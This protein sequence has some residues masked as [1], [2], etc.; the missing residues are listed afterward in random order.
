MQVQDYFNKIYNTFMCCNV[1][2]EFCSRANIGISRSDAVAN[3][4]ATKLEFGLAEFGKHTCVVK[5][6]L[7]K[8]FL[9]AYG[10]YFMN[11]IE[12]M[13]TPTTPCGLG[14][15]LQWKKTL[16]VRPDEPDDE[17]KAEY[18]R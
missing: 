18:F 4:F 13:N 5:R 14:R 11:R 2:S 15:Y 6:R 7:D 17:A 8:T 16:F 3:F 10:L 1:G 12:K 9:H